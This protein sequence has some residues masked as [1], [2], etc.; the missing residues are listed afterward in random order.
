ML[1]AASAG[2]TFQV[3]SISGAFQGVIERRHACRIEDHAVVRVRRR[4]VPLGDVKALGEIGEEPDVERRAFHH[5]QPAGFEQRSVVDGFDQRESLDV[6][7][8][9][10]GETAEE[11]PRPDGPRA[12]QS[13][14]ASAAACID[15]LSTSSGPAADTSPSRAPSIGLCTSIVSRTHAPAVDEVVAGNDNVPAMHIR[16]RSVSGRCQHRV[17]ASSGARRRWNGNRR[18]VNAATVPKVDEAVGGRT[19]L[20]R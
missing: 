16:H 13:G 3:A 11:G 8:D 1:P 10:V 18:V 12:A 14:N 6:A 5:A 4:R 15:S 20:T 7:L 9:Q 19:I 17:F 2:P